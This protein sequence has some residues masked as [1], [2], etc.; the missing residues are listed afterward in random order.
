[1]KKYRLT[2]AKTGKLIAE[3]GDYIIEMDSKGNLI[4]EPIQP[5][6]QQTQQHDDIIFLLREIYLH[7]RKQKKQHEDA[8]ILLR[9]IC[10]QTE[11]IIRQNDEIKEERYVQWR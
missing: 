2:E 6:I 11:K 4:V 10:L 9:E 7:T 3:F 1:M 8:M 5:T